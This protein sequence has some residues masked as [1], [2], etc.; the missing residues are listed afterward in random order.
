MTAIK[1]FDKCGEGLQVFGGLEKV[2]KIFLQGGKVAEL[3][4]LATNPL[5][6]LAAMAFDELFDKMI[7][8]TWQEIFDR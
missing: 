1:N 7:A 4:K 3:F 2:N 8:K 5:E 6:G